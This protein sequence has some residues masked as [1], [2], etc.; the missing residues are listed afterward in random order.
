MDERSRAFEFT[1]T[2]RTTAIGSIYIY[3]SFTSYLD[4]KYALLTKRGQDGW[5]LAKFFFAFFWFYTKHVYNPPPPPPPP[6]SRSGLEKTRLVNKGFIIWPRRELS[7]RNERGKSR[8]RIANQ[9]TWFRC[10]VI[11]TRRGCRKKGFSGI[12]YSLFWRGKAG[13]GGGGW[14]V[15]NELG[16]E[17][18]FLP[19]MVICFVPFQTTPRVQANPWGRY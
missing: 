19:W 1:L 14:R 10:M 12:G 15:E 7:L 18:T 3:Q 16:N 5:I 11:T 8:A 17:A 6:P 13:A 2:I 9:N 4:K